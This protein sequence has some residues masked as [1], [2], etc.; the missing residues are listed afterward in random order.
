MPA[1]VIDFAVTLKNLECTKQIT[2]A[3]TA[4]SG[5]IWTISTGKIIHSAQRYVGMGQ[6]CAP[7]GPKHDTLW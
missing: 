4:R 2:P 6:N 3:K 7:K 5:H 1:C